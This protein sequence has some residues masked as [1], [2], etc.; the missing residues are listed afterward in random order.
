MLIRFQPFSGIFQGFKPIQYPYCRHK[1]S[2]SAICW[3]AVLMFYNVFGGAD[4][5]W[6]SKSLHGSI[7]FIG[8][9]AG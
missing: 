9:P 5:V 4:V 8:D 2:E 6:A 1:M 3:S 7:T